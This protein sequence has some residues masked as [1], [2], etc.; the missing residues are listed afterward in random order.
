MLYGG[1][2]DDGQLY[3]QL[4]TLEISEDAGQGA[5]WTM[6]TTGGFC[7]VS[8]SVMEIQGKPERQGISL[9]FY[10]TEQDY[11]QQQKVVQQNREENVIAAQ[12]Q[13]SGN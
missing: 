6:T 2:H 5:N 13:T 9:Y 10:P 1:F 7:R 3:R 4:S 11:R 12:E 8:Y